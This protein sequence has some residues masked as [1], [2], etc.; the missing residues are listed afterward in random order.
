M[1]LVNTATVTLAAVLTIA[2]ASPPAEASI[3]IGEHI[4]GVRLGDPLATV[5]ARHGEPSRKLVGDE[6]ADYG[7]FWDKLK[8]HTLMT[9]E[10]ETVYLVST[11]S[12][13]QR[14]SRHI[15]PGV[16]ERTA[17]QRLRGERCASYFDADRRRQVLGCDVRSDGDV[18]TSFVIWAGRVRE[19][20]LMPATT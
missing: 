2:L 14:T 15:G 3:V 10:T 1:R 13:K 4:S 6:S 9:A 5:T 11:T 8:L 19:V 18:I 17:R 7:L 20:V 16:R 12:T